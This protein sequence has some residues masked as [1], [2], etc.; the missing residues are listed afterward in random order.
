M[1]SRVADAIYWM[2]RY[3]ERAENLARFVDVNQNLALDMPYD[4]EDRQWSPLVAVTGDYEAFADRY[5]E[6]N[7]QSV[8]D[9]L[10]FDR[11]NPNSIFRCLTAARESARSVREVISTEMW[12]Q[13][14]RSLLMLREAEIT[15]HLRDEPAAF[16]GRLRGACHLFWGITDATMTHGE[17]WNFARL[18]R[19]IERA[20][21]TSRILD[22]KY[23]IL[24]P[25]VD[26]VGS[27]YDNLQWAALLKSASAHEMYRKR[28]QRIV[29]AQVVEFLVLDREFPRAIQYC[30]CEAER[31]LHA[32]SG[33][34]DATYINKAE[35]RLGRLR[36]ELAYADVDGI[37]STGLHEFLD[38]FQ[39]KLNKVGDAVYQTFFDLEPIEAPARSRIA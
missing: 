38:A 28:Y 27:P 4:D 22:V 18:G 6:A 39:V 15:N 17:P 24:L 8:I 21:K 32:I 3:I 36:A 29:P 7:E 10:T 37:L 34:H 31:A 1:L 20:D 2:G 11:E 33:S 19:M 25:R 13:V 16:F 14:N 5:G 12:E 35:Q 26:Y 30:L 9:F 23:F